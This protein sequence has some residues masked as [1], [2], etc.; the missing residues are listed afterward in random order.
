MSHRIAVVAFALIASLATGTA[1]AGGARPPIGGWIGAF[2]DGSTVELYVQGDGRC[3][4][5][6]TGYAP[7][8][9]T[10]SW[11]PT[12]VGGILTITYVNAGFQN[13]AYYSVTWTGNSSFVLSDPYF[14][15]LMRSR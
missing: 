13:R 7:T 1:H 12:S 14:R 5:G 6:P 2:D 4:Y 3:M 8:V 9:G 15:V 11:S 10:C